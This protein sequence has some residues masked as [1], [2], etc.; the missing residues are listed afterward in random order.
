MGKSAKPRKARRPRNVMMPKLIPEAYIVDEMPLLVAQLHAGIV[1]LIDRPS[2]EAANNMAHQF[3][4]IAAVLAHSASGAPV[5]GTPPAIP[6]QSAILVL[7]AVIDRH[8]R[9]GKVMVSTSEAKTLRAAAAG[10]DTILSG[11]T[12]NA[13]LWANRDVARIMASL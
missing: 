12:V 4:V 5:Q 6:I 13:W 9:T 11:V 2:C 7:E 8:A 1:T 10:L 3:T